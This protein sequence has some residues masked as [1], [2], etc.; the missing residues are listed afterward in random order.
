[1]SEL[2]LFCLA[3]AEFFTIYL[4]WHH[5]RYEKK[6][7]FH[8]CIGTMA[9]K[10]EILRAKNFTSQ[11]CKRLSFLNKMA[12]MFVFLYKSITEMHK[13]EQTR[14]F[15][16]ACN[17]AKWLQIFCRFGPRRVMTSSHIEHEYMSLMVVV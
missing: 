2:G 3:L 1:M 11:N 10:Q 5:D 7:S 14:L 6:W 13:I 15:R 8:S 17:F 16:E 12:L 9:V 4:F